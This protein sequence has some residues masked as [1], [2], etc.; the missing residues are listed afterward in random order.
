MRPRT[1]RRKIFWRRR[2]SRVTAANKRR[3]IVAGGKAIHERK[4]E[5]TLGS[6]GKFQKVKKEKRAKDGKKL[7]MG[8]QERPSSG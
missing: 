5:K 2:R 6:G 4:G 1:Q 3:Y 8:K 7:L